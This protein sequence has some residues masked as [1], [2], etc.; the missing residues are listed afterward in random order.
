MTLIDQEDMMDKFFP[1]Q[2]TEMPFPT[3]ANML[4][5]RYE[6]AK[7]AAIE[8]LAACS[9]FMYSMITAKQYVQ[10]GDYHNLL[11]GADKL[12]KITD[13]TDRSTAVL[14]GDGAGAVIIGEVFRRQRY[15]KL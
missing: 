7:L 13:L 9:G 3:V 11:V 1:P 10:S 12:S 6:T 2:R 8:Q 15:Y 14:F 5:E 4:Q